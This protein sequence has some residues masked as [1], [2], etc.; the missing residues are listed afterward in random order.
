MTI[1]HNDHSVMPPY[2]NILSARRSSRSGR[3]LSRAP[4]EVVEEE[5]EEVEVDP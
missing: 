5:V 1:D 2:N 3:L 4:L